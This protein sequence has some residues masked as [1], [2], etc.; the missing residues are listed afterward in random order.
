M[1]IVGFFV[2][3]GHQ[4]LDLAGPFAAFEAVAKVAG[5][6]L[7]RLEVL[8]RAGGLVPSSGG[9]SG[10]TIAAGDASV[11]TLVVCGGDIAPMLQPG[12][13]QTI[14]RLAGRTARIASVCTG[15][16]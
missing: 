7:Y 1:H 13:V 4:I 16:F 8:S 15:A 11:N 6:P 2:Y 12:E 14:A 10:T 9:V 3:P 5:R